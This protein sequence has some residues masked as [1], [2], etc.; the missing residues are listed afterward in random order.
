MLQRHKSFRDLLI[1]LI[2]ALSEPRYLLLEDDGGLQTGHDVLEETTGGGVELQLPAGHYV[3]VQQ[4]HKI[5]HLL[6]T[7]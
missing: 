3:R 5:R 2:H 6:W 7:E 1:L 4:L